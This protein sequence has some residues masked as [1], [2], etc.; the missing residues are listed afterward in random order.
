MKRLCVICGARVININPK[1]DTCGSICTRAKHGGRS[2]VDQIMVDIQTEEQEELRRDREFK[3]H[4]EQ[5][6]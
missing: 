3:P 6:V 5:P 2:R 1:V 4:H